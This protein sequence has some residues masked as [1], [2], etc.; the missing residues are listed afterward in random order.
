MLRRYE[1]PKDRLHDFYAE[2][3]REEIKAD[4][5][6][7]SM[8]CDA[9]CDPVTTSADEQPAKKATGS[10]YPLNLQP[11]MFDLMKKKHPQNAP[12]KPSCNKSP[13]QHLDE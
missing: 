8:F 13:R 7:V 6:E 11:N 5:P 12:S 3:E 4:V 10:L 1:T 2:S 9:T